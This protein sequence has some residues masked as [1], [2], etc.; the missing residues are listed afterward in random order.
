EEFRIVAGSKTPGSTPVDSPPMPDQHIIFGGCR[1]KGTDIDSDK[2]I[3]YFEATKGGQP[4]LFCGQGMSLHDVVRQEMLTIYREGDYR[5]TVGNRKADFADTTAKNLFD[6][7]L[8]CFR[9]NNLASECF[10]QQRQ[11]VYILPWLGDQTVN[12]LSALL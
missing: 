3:I 2:K 8:H 1:W 11:H 5:I 10:I 6:E 12:T 7:G 4:P 9:N